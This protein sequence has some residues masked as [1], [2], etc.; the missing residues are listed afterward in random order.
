MA[1]PLHAFSVQ[2]YKFLS[3]IR[4]RNWILHVIPAYNCGKETKKAQLTLL[5]G[6]VIKPMVSAVR[7]KRHV[8]RTL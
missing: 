5:V 7:N 2:R 1:S 8:V 4:S 3:D 6:D